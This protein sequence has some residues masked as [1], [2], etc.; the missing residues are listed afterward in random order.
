MFGGKMFIDT[1][2]HTKYSDG[3]GSIQDILK[4]AKKRGIGLAITDHNVV[5]GA[6]KAARRTGRGLKFA[7][8]TIGEILPLVGAI[9]FWTWLV[10]SELRGDG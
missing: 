7:I 3:T 9:P 10:W 6:V 8:S 5:K 1:H 4:N 2:I